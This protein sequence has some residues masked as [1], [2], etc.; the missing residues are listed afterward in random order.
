[1]GAL[2]DLGTDWVGYC[3]SVGGWGC[4]D[5][6]GVVEMS[7]DG[8][9]IAEDIFIRMESGQ[10]LLLDGDV[11]DVRLGKLLERVGNALA[12]ELVEIVAQ[13]NRK[14]AEESK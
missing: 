13:G 2:S 1:V 6:K 3:R 9:A 4:H 7:H 5:W 8:I 14:V 11:Q 10:S 12:D